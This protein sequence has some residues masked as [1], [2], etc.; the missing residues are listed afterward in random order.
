MS[1]SIPGN[2]PIPYFFIIFNESIVTNAI[3]INPD[4]ATATHV[5]EPVKDLKLEAILGPIKPADMENVF[6]KPI[7][8]ATVVPPLNSFVIH[9]QYIGVKL[10]VVIIVINIIIY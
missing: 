5:Y 10:E 9:T 6:I 7:E 4:P 3:N 1:S 8:T 2:C